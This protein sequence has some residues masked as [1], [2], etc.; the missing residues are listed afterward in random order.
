MK[1]GYLSIYLYNLDHP[2]LFIW[3]MSNDDPVLLSAFIEYLD[4]NFLSRKDKKII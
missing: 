3:M 4:N 2:N 1:Y